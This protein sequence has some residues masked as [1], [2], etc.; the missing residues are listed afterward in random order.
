MR[1]DLPDGGHALFTTRVDGN[2]SSVGGVEAELGEAARERLRTQ[3][4]LRRLAPGYQVHGTTVQRSR[5]DAD[6][7]VRDSGA[8]AAPGR[9]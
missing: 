1:F 4:G 6:I 3:L 8:A 2:L 7:F 5:T 9:G